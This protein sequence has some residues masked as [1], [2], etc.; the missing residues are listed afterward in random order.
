MPIHLLEQRERV[1]RLSQAPKWAEPFPDTRG[2]TGIDELNERREFHGRL[3]IVDERIAGRR[4]F[5]IKIKGIGLDMI[6]DQ[7]AVNHQF[8]G[9][10]TKMGHR[11][12][13]SVNILDPVETVSGGNFE[14]RLLNLNVM[15][16]TRAEQHPM[17]AKN[18]TL[19][20]AVGCSVLDAQFHGVSGYSPNAYS[21]RIAHADS[22]LSPPDL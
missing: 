20:I 14:R 19:R 11:N 3:M 5:E 2:V 7:I 12:P 4:R 15:S 17:G 6:Q 9:A 8:R 18:D 22:K 13:V 10:L 1:N 21:M 16:F